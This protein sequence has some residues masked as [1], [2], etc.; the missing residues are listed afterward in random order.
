MFNESKH[1][2]FF[3]PFTLF[4]SVNSTCTVPFLLSYL[5]PLS[6]SCSGSLLLWVP[7]AVLS[8]FCLVLSI[9]ILISVLLHQSSQCSQRTSIC[10]HT[11]ILWQRLVSLEVFRVSE[12]GDKDPHIK[13]LIVSFQLQ[14]KRGVTKG[15][16]SGR[17]TKG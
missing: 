2:E 12:R 17:S 9:S 3:S 6:P 5:A 10:T 7:S 4:F 1:M 13:Q 14:P 8:S 16:F 15:E 11:V